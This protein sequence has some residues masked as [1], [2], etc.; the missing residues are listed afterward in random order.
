MKRLFLTLMLA[1]TTLQTHAKS[2]HSFN[3]LH[4]TGEITLNAKALD[5]NILLTAYG[6]IDYYQRNCAGLTRY[7]KQLT[8]ETLFKSD[9]YLLKGS[10]L[11]NT[12]A[13]KDGYTHASKFA[14][15]DLRWELFNI[16][17]RELFR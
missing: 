5:K 17:A 13:F 12:K 2:T 11:T 1:I 14:C 9:L 16:G 8:M 10:E 7:G 3:V 15:D 4:D 6:V